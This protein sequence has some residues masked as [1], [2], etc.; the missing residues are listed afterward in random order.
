M[1]M[2]LKWMLAPGPLAKEERQRQ[3][4]CPDWPSILPLRFTVLDFSPSQLLPVAWV[5]WG[6]IPRSPGPRSPELVLWMTSRAINLGQICVHAHACVYACE[7]VCTPFLQY[8]VQMYSSDIDYEM[9]IIRGTSPI[10]MWLKM[11]YSRISRMLTYYCLL[12][13]PTL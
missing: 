3:S 7:C 13:W 8:E 2:P 11:R 6:Q 10:I 4:V 12:R 9:T 1:G 5:Q